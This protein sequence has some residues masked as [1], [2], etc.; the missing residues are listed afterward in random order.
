MRR[1]LSFL[2]GLTLA[3]ICLVWAQQP[4]DKVLQTFQVA[5]GLEWRL[6]ASEPM[7]CNPTCIDIDHHGRIWVCE[8]VNYRCRLRNQPLNRPAGDRIVVLE[9]LDGD[10]KADRATTFYQAPEFIAPLGIAVAPNASGRGQRIYV[11]HSPYIYVFEDA[12]DDLR[13]DGPPQVL[14]SGFRGYDHDHGVH[15]IHFGPD[16]KLYFTC[17]DTGIDG[18]RDRW[19]KVWKTN[20]TDCRAGTVWRC[21]ANGSN[22]EML[23]HNFRNHY[24]PAIDSFGTLFVS[25]NDDDGSQQTRICHVLFGGN[26]GYW[27]RGRGESHWHEEQPGVV[28]KVLR[29]WFG[30]PTGM[31][32]YE[33][34][35]IPWTGGRKPEEYY[36]RLLHTDAG[37]RQVR[38]YYVR[39]KGA[40]FEI[41]RQDV[42]T[43]SDNWFRPSDIC[44][45]PDGSL[46]V[47]DWY[48]PGVGGHGMGDITRGRIY[49]LTP[50]GYAAYRVVPPD[51]SSEAGILAGLESPNL[52]AR[53][54]SWQ[55]FRQLPEKRQEQLARQILANEQNLIL[56]ARLAWLL[57]QTPQWSNHWALLTQKSQDVRWQMMLVRA[58][59]DRAEKLEQAPKEVREW[60]EGL[61]RPGTPL[62]VLGEIAIALRDENSVYAKPLI[63]KLAKLYPGNEHFYL[64]ALGIAVGQEDRTRRETILGDF[65]RQFPRWDERVLELIW[66]W[67]PSQVIAHLD[68]QVLDEN[69]PLAQRLRM[70]DILAASD[71]I[72]GGEVLLR[73]LRHNVPELQ[74]RILQW[75]KLYLPTKW[76]P[77]RR[78][79]D[80]EAILRNWL[81]QPEL[82]SSALEIIAVTE[83]DI[84]LPQLTQL[85]TDKRKNLELRRQ[86][87]STLAAMRS[88]EATRILVGFLQDAELATQAVHALG[89]Q[90]S[91]AALEALEKV[92][93]SNNL[94]LSLRLDAVAALASTR[95][96]SVWLLEHAS[97]FEQTVHAEAIRW[98]RNSPFQ[99]V[100]N[101]ALVLFPATKLNPRQLPDIAQLIKRRGDPQHGRR[102]F[103]DNKDL[104]CVRCHTV[105]G[106]GG[107]IGPELGA[108]GSKASRENL[109]ESILY[110]DKAIA[111][112]F[113][114]WVVETKQGLIV[115]GILVEETPQ[116]LV[117]RDANG[118]DWKM[119]KH[120]IMERSKSP[121]SLMPSDL[122][123]YMTDQDLVDL[124]EF[125]QTLKMMPTK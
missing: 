56:S 39:I 35:L 21:D 108:I 13:A 57:I 38:I 43:S 86:A 14:L 22:I 12:D 58:A 93:Q 110:P 95:S 116:H 100:R 92:A 1:S 41:D 51:W 16:G 121:R 18:I 107:K 59:K 115:Q 69:R 8:S 60:V 10:G 105:N 70:L 88:T 72:T 85:A 4:S 119:S 80:L 19:G 7:F 45:A 83:S 123:Q 77:L 64:A 50:K 118:K 20:N 91:P 111:D 2:T 120:D 27:P 24:E 30:S 33:G 37:P 79:S 102:L 66:E 68:Q 112:Q 3:A 76:S 117:L 104:G 75:L 106:Q 114:Q 97:E 89:R 96:G 125:L 87:V 99:D 81:T 25:D 31:A 40:G 55:A 54:G 42:V 61:I 26:Y 32:W 47:S 98:L 62:P 103:F 46:F 23:A 49:R 67:R 65:A 52:S 90:A 109:F 71:G 11:C 17:G 124:V 73:V 78:S 9:D 94:D 113:I 29:T 34:D 15:G 28:H 74:P 84:W 122:V 82:Q 5:E 36:G 101:K 53:V 48:D 44:V 63:Y 6:F